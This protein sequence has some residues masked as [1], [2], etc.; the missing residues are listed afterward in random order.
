M[1]N[2]YILQKDKISELLNVLD[3]F[4]D[5]MKSF[6]TKYNNRYKY[7]INIFKDIVKDDKIFTAEINIIRNE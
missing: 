4:T 2:K 3:S 1:E 7:G 5:R 6:N